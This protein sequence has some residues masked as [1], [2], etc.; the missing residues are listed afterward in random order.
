MATGVRAAGRVPSRPP[1]PRALV[2]WSLVLG[3]LVSGL[4]V[5]G[6]SHAAFSSATAHP[7]NSWSAGTVALT[8]DSNTA[9]LFNVTGVR[10][11]TTGTKCI[12][13]TYNGTVAARVKVYA[14]STSGGLLP[15]LNL[16][17]DQGTGGS[18]ASC[19]GFS[20]TTLWGPNTADGLTATNWA[21][22]LG[23]WTP[24]G[25][26]QTRT[27]RFRWSLVDDEKAEATTANMTFTWEAQSS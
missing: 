21:T 7:A 17:V 3:V 26:G 12:T 9:A 13:V 14:S 22:G 5:Y 24:N 1:V 8:D 15:Y 6:A 27:Y 2:L 23:N 10:P 18:Y 19:T 20:G 4:G 16:T 11:P 25:S